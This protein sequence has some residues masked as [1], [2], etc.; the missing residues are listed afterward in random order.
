MCGCSFL[1]AK[2]L[3]GRVCPSITVRPYCPRTNF[4]ICSSIAGESNKRQKPCRFF[5]ANDD[6]WQYTLSHSAI[7]LSPRWIFACP[8]IFIRPNQAT[9]AS[10]C[11]FLLCAIISAKDSPS[12]DSGLVVVMWG[13]NEKTEAQPHRSAGQRTSQPIDA[14]EYHQNK[15]RQK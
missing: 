9:N 7:P 14:C 10:H 2:M 6:E 15:W 5:S 8:K 13:D 4:K 1:L 3:A 12:D 11:A